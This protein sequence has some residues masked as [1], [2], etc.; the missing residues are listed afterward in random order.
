MNKRNP[1]LDKLLRHAAVVLSVETFC[2]KASLGGIFSLVG[3]CWM[4]K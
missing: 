1:L 3:R 2:L 4:R